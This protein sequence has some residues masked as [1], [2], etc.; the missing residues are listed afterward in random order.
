MSDDLLS[1]DIA[2][3]EAAL[4]ELDEISKTSETVPAPIPVGPVP[5]K[6]D[7]SE[8]LYYIRK[9]GGMG[10]WG[11]ATLAVWDIMNEISC[12]YSP[13]LS[14]RLWLTLHRRPDLWKK[15]GGLY[16]PDGRFHAYTKG[17]EWG[18]PPFFQSYGCPT[19]GTEP[20]LHSYPSQ[21][22]DGGWTNEG[23]NEAYNYRL[24]HELKK[25]GT[26]SSDE[27]I[28]WLNASRPIRIEGGLG[29]KGH[30][31]A[32]VGY[33]LE[34][35]TFKYANSYGD[36]WGSDGYGTFT[37]QQLDNQQPAIIGVFPTSTC[38]CR[39]HCLQA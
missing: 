3:N 37:F 27:F 28:K 26:I 2:I 7:L 35:Q 32:V 33:D 29:K 23:G 12:P 5:K 31:V 15:D 36:K 11:Y 39:P 6:V 25:L 8:Y 24:G 13:N 16:S 18:K 20:T 17:P 30:V 34:D 14:M 38:A 9:Q 21:W 19:E 4:A 1:N 22:T 10:C